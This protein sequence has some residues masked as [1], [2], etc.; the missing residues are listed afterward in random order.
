ME[1]D[2]HFFLAIIHLI[3]IVP[4]FLF[5]GF[6]RASTPDWLYLATFA[7]G[8]VILVYHGFKLVIRLKNN[9]ASWWI[10]ALHIL[11]VAP[12][13]LFIGWHKKQTP[14]FAYELLLMLGFAAAGYHL[15]SLVRMMEA[16]PEPKE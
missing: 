13:L 1:L 15:F 7:I 9:S 11:I 6:Q 12:L 14:R 5:I 16:H 10:N 4:F 3:I 8:A 2:Q